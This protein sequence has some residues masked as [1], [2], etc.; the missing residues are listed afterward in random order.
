MSAPNGLPYEENNGIEPDID[1]IDEARQE[2]GE[3]GCCP[4]TD[5]TDEE[6]EQEAE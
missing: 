1:A 4:I 2:N 3:C 6:T 5:K